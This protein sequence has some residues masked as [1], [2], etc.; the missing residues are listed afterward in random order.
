[1]NGDKNNRFGELIS[2]PRMSDIQKRLLLKVLTYMQNVE[3]KE[4]NLEIFDED[5]LIIGKI[6]GNRLIVNLEQMVIEMNMAQLIN[7]AILFRKPEII[8]SLL[9]HGVEIG[10]AHV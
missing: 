10:R 8:Y 1:M 9:K 3:N 2:D 6:D 7:D 4:S 5:M